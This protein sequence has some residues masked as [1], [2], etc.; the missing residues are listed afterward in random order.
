MGREQCHR[1]TRNE[2]S[3]QQSV[4]A[5]SYITRVTHVIPMDMCWGEQIF[6]YFKQG[7]ST[8]GKGRCGPS[9]LEYFCE[10]VNIER[11]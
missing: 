7:L 2:L 6:G 11:W 9:Q 3:T 4:L 8:Q 10:K 5:M 1:D